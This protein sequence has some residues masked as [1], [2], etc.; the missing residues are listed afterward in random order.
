MPMLNHKNIV[1]YF[2]CWVEAVEPSK[3]ALANSL[4]QLRQ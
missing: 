4:S 3:I 2:S 1:R